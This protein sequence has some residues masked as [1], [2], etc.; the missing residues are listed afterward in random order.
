[1]EALATG[2]SIICARVVVVTGCRGKVSDNTSSKSSI[3]ALR[4]ARI[5]VRAGLVM[6]LA[7]VAKV[8]CARIVVVTIFD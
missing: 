5:G 8:G 1:M 6:A 7:T 4:F 3:A 2:T